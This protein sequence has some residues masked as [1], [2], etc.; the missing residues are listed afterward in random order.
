MCFPSPPARCHT[1]QQSSSD[2]AMPAPV[3]SALLGE[4]G[5]ATG[6]IWSQAEVTMD[7]FHQRMKG[8]KRSCDAYKKKY[9]KVK[10]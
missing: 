7:E 1:A 8:V 5:F 6:A 3:R 2:S 9:A 4:M 10:N